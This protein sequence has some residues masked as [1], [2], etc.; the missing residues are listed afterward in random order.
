[1]PGKDLEAFEQR[2]RG[3]L[4]ENI[5]PFWLKHAVDNEHGGFIGQMSN[6][7]VAEERAH[8]GLIL[9]TRLLWTFSALQR[10]EPDPRFLELAHRAYGYL[11]KHFWDDRFGGAFWRVD[12]QGDL[13]DDKKKIYGQAFCVYALS[14]YCLATGDPTALERARE[15]FGLIERHSH[16]VAHGGT[17]RRASAIGRSLRTLG[18]ARRT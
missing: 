17:S 13:L 10:S 9:N 15:M 8:K 1:M 6:D 3:E 7:L 11:E 2:V 18:L 16:D 4:H 12:H 5:I 14:E